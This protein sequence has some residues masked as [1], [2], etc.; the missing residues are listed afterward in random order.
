MDTFHRSAFGVQVW[1]AHALKESLLVRGTGALGDLGLL[2]D[3]AGRGAL[4]PREPC[5]QALLQGATRPSFFWGFVAGG[6]VPNAEGRE[7]SYILKKELLNL[8]RISPY[9]SL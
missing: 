6:N 2:P 3:L 5:E 1:K 8:N 9:P 7:V 4:G